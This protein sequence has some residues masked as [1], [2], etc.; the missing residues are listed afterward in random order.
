MAVVYLYLRQC[1]L[2]VASDQSIMCQHYY[3]LS[4]YYQCGQLCVVKANTSKSRQ[5]RDG[6]DVDVTSLGG[7]AINGTHH[8]SYTLKLAQ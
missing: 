2:L 3:L 7:R 4:F 5:S 6:R 8:L 1:M